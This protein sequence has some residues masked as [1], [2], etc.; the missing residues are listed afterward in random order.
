MKV[1]H[2]IAR[3]NLGG[4]ARWLET[5]T[6]EQIA[7]G[8]EVVVATGQVQGDEPVRRASAG[9]PSACLPGHGSRMSYKGKRPL[10]V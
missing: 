6:A 5:L 10:E 4:T 9:Q 8:D 1:L 2:V 7:A 3:V